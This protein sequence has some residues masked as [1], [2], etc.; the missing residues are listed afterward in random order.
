LHATVN[1]DPGCWG[2]RAEHV[3]VRRV[4]AIVVVTRVQELMVMELV[5]TKLML[6]I[7]VLLCD[8]YA[9]S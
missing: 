7:T 4:V 3:S 2:Q 8:R 1:H 9:S 5:L 6:A